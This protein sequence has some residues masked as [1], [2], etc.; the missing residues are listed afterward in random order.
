MQRT[1]GSLAI[2]PNAPSQFYNERSGPATGER[3]ISVMRDLIVPLVPTRKVWSA[4]P[5]AAQVPPLVALA[6]VPR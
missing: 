4:G 6:V 5:A 1:T 3:G 2:S